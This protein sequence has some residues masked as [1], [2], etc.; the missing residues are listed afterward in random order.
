MNCLIKLLKKIIQ[1]MNCTSCKKTKLTPCDDCNYVVSA[2]CVEY[3][4]DRLYFEDTSVKNG[5]SRTL[6]E[7]LES[8]DEQ[9]SGCLERE[10]KLVSGDYNVILEDVCKILLLN[11]VSNTDVTY[12][13]TLPTS[14]DFVNKTLI[15]KDISGHEDPSGKISWEFS[16]EIVIDQ[17]ESTDEFKKMAWAPHKILHLTLLKKDGLNYSWV[18]TSPSI[19]NP[20]VIT[21]TNADLEG[22]W[23]IVEELKLY[24]KGKHRQLQGTV[25]GGSVPSVLIN[26]ETQDI[27]PTE[28]YFLVAVDA[29]PYRALLTISAFIA[30]SFPGGAALTSGEN[31]S[32]FG[33][34]WYVE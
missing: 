32:L 18:V 22:D 9:S 33:V 29:S 15:F 10:A 4:G 6:S 7:I 27:P 30:I 8:M 26:L 13:I 28:G 19:G 3:R 16:Q 1:T 23:E 21:L 2:D 20:E 34:S 31:L 11:G 17:E 24:R 12:T 5:S 14:D 25:T